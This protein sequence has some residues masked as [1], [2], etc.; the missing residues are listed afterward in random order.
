M[1]ILRISSWPSEEKQ[2]VGLAAY[3]LSELGP[4]NST[5]IIA[6]EQGTKSLKSHGYV[7]AIEIDFFEKVHLF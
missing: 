4:E 5:V 6:K 2:G 7:E 1:R 3:Y